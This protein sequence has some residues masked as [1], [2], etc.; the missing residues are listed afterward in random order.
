VVWPGLPRFLEARK[1]AGAALERQNGIRFEEVFP[2]AEPPAN[3]QTPAS[4]G[5]AIMVYDAQKVVGAIAII[6]IPDAR[7]DLALRGI[8]VFAGLDVG[9]DL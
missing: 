9:S 4:C 6:G 7:A 8:V 2:G 5:A 3:K 1:L